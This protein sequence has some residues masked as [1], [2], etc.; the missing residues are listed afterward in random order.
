MEPA[1]VEFSHS[2]S[3]RRL[4]D[5]QR[6][7]MPFTEADWLRV[8]QVAAGI[9]AELIAQD[10]RLTMGGEPTFVSI[11]EP[12]SAQWNIDAL[13]SMKRISA[14]GWRPVRCFITGKGNGIQAS[15]C[16]VGRWAAIGVPM[17]SPSGRMQTS[18]P[19]EIITT[20]LVRPRLSSLLKR[21]RGAFR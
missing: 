18:L 4:N 5:P 1:G 7:S 3:V 9:D 21:L 12:E 2:I 19:K 15:P 14:R 17:V 8:R 13:G 16:R 20:I 11:D 10:V 6:P